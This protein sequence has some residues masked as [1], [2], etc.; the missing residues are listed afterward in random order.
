MRFADVRTRLNEENPWPPFYFFGREREEP[1]N[2]ETQQQQR[3]SFMKLIFIN[4]CKL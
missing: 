3:N 1:A 2:G 4:H